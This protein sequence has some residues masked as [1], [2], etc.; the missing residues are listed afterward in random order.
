P[1]HVAR[2]PARSSYHVICTNSSSTATQMN[3][4]PR[5]RMPRQRETPGDGAVLTLNGALK[6]LPPS[7]ETADQITKCS[8][9]SEYCQTSCHPLGLPRPAPDVDSVWTPRQVNAMT[10][11][12]L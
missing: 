1:Y 11:F 4:R 12:G 2:K 3:S 6:V 8:G 7:R 10:P 9:I 5:L